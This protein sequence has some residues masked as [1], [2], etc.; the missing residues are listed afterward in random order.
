DLRSESPL[1][2]SYMFSESLQDFLDET[3]YLANVKK[4]SEYAK[5]LT[6]LFE[7]TYQHTDRE[8]LAYQAKQLAGRLV[9]SYT[10]QQKNN[11]LEQLKT[12]DE[13]EEKKLLERVKQLEI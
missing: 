2:P 6:L 4:D 1:L 5:M 12:A 9:T 8:E 10:Q 7:E 3:K 11:I 13:H